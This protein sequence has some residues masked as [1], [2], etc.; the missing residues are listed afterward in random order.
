LRD[1]SGEGLLRSL[2]VLL[3]VDVGVPVHTTFSRRSPGLVLAT[4]LAQAQASGP[5]HV[6]IDATGLKV[7]GAGEWLVEKHG[8]RGMRTWRKLRLAVVRRTAALPPVSAV[9]SVSARMR[10]LSWA[11]KIRRCG[12][13]VS[14]D[15]AEA[16]AAAVGL[17]S[18]RARLGIDR[19][20]CHWHEQDHPSAPSRLNS[21]WADVSSSLVW[22]AKTGHL[23]TT[24]GTPA[25]GSNKHDY[26]SSCTPNAMLTRP[27]AAER[28][29]GLGKTAII[30]PH[31][32]S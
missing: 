10:S 24:I 17:R 25:G 12:R 15:D 7:Y 29:S 4:A 20:L 23:V 32:T 16:G 6:V 2:T 19:C 22:R 13:A 14:S 26:D 11:V 8:E 30:L 1:V 9:R 5:V 3:G 27:T 21:R 18:G 28:R 31:G